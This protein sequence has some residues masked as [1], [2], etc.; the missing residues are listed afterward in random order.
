[1]GASGP[2][3]TGRPRTVR[4]APTGPTHPDA[5]G[6]QAGRYAAEAWRALGADGV[7]R[8]GAD[9]PQDVVRALDPPWRQEGPDCP[10]AFAEPLR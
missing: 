5:A 4:S 9:S 3:A 7:F 6:R 10:L 1:K 2:G 8:P